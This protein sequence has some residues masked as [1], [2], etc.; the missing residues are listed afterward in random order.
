MQGI[1]E[2]LFILISCLLNHQVFFR[3][4]GTKGISAKSEVEFLSNDH[5]GEDPNE[6][7]RIIKSGGRV[8]QFQE[9]DG[10]RNGPMR[11]WLKDENLPGLAMTRSIGDLIASTI[12]V[13]CEPG[14]KK[15]IH[16]IY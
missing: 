5:K 8:E 16:R 11:V 14:K 6:K 1:A 12:G 9:D 4:L 13:T 15:L 7:M 10:S 3:N 2:Q